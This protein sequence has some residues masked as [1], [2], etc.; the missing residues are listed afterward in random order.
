MGVQSSD[1]KSLALGSFLSPSLKG[2]SHVPP[3]PSSNQMVTPLLLFLRQPRAAGGPSGS[4]ASGL[5][6]SSP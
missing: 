4:V 5:A 3:A 6:G 1:V 2:L